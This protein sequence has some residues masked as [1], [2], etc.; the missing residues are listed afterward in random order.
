VKF[1]VRFRGR[2]IAHPQK[3]QEQLVWII[4]QLEDLAN[5]ELAPVMEGRAM[6]MMVAPK[7]AVLQQLAVA[8]A[9]SEK[10]RK[11]QLDARLAAKKGRPSGA[12]AD[13]APSGAG[14]ESNPGIADG[15]DKDDDVATE[16]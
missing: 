4:S 12:G 1:T 10:E 5:V 14:L 13:G 16:A 8:R 15:D 11:E 6:T 3:A 9:Q 2:E 7:P